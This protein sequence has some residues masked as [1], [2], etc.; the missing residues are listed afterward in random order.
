[1][2]SHR[3][4]RG[5]S[6]FRERLP[7]ILIE[8]GS[9][10]F[11]VLLALGVDDWREARRNEELAEF[12][13]RSIVAELRANEKELREAQSDNRLVLERIQR[14]LSARDTSRT[15][16][17]EVDVNVAQLTSPAWDLARATEALRYMD[18]D[19]LLETSRLYDLQAL[20]ASDQRELLHD[21]GGMIQS[22]DAGIDQFR[23]RLSIDL[24]LGDSLLSAYRRFLARRGDAR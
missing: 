2:T 17:F 13:R 6:R 23:G 5:R 16:R 20:L 18:Y 7:D 15:V 1:M 4:P 11:A 10:L 19:W 3:E 12:A 14:Q 22:N 8:V 24:T 9:V 21:L